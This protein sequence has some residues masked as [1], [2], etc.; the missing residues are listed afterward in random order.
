M[1]QVVIGGF[2]FAH[3][4][5]Q[6]LKLATVVNSNFSLP[7]PTPTPETG[8]VSGEEE[9]GV[10][11][12]R[13][14]NREVNSG[15][16][17]PIMRSSR[18]ARRVSKVSWCF[19]VFRVSFIL[20]CWVIDRVHWPTASEGRPASSI[21]LRPRGKRV[22]N[23]RGTSPGKASLHHSGHQTCTIP[24]VAGNGRKTPLRYFY[25]NSRFVRTSADRRESARIACLSASA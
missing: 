13:S 14:R 20:S 7:S 24:W 18:L 1:P 9:L 4:F 12:C 3:F 11:P 19:S 25:N 22:L 16:R 6:L 23:T 21:Q 17:G 8:N 10:F 2:V 5:D 15:F